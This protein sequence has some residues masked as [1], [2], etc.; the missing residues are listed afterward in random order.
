MKKIIETERLY[1]RELVMEDVQELSKVLSDPESMQYYNEPF[2]EEKVEK[3]I[4]WNIDNYKKYNHGL[5]AVIL[6]DGEKFI[7]DCGITM[8]AIENEIVPEIGFHIIKKYWNKGY[9]TEAAIACKDYAFDVLNY[10]KIFSYTTLENISSQKVAQK[11]GMQTYKMFE[12]N[13]EKQ[14]A[15]VI[16][17]I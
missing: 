7:G 11:I 4:Q 9:A 15:Q 5:W 12:K 1:L 3:W 10:P 2:N 14:I 8:Q 13:G 17:N 6:K 16:F